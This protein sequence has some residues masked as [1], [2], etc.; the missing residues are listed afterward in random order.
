MP[1]TDDSPLDRGAAYTAEAQRAERFNVLLL[2]RTGAGKSTLVNALFD[3]DLART[4]IGRP[5]TERL[6]LH[7]VPGKPLGVYDAPGS[8]LGTRSSELVHDLRDRIKSHTSG[9]LNEQ[10]HMALYCVH[11][12]D[13][14][15][16]PA[17][18]G[19]I[20]KV[21]AL[22]L[23]VLLVLTRA[24]LGHDGRLTRSAFEMAAYLESLQL[25]VHAGRA[26]A[27]VAVDDVETGESAHGLDALYEAMLEAAAPAVRSAIDRAV[28][29][30]VGRQ[31]WARRRNAGMAVLKAAGEAF[32][33]KNSDELLE[34][35][36]SEVAAIYRVESGEAQEAAGTVVRLA[37]TAW[38]VTR[39][40]SEAP[41]SG[42]AGTFADV[43]IEPAVITV[44]GTVWIGVC[45]T[46]ARGGLR[47]PDGSLD[48]ERL[49]HDVE[50]DLLRRWRTQT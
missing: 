10:I 15:L 42:G 9:D 46:L 38:S 35:L 20:R 17:E 18:E 7:A 47:T 5:V 16:H 19:L 1:P 14:R 13:A 29:K 3:V 12:I 8:E 36:I 25:P 50:E 45:E 4:G 48:L 26:H 33:T 40:A 39:K 34:K 24:P 23:P 43:I 32:S 6:T 31:S 44:I 2:G 49:R 37:R 27:V 30:S 11:A 28:A 41:S 21:S 22:G